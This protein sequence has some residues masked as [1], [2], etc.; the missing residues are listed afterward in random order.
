MDTGERPPKEANEGGSVRA[1]RL[2]G[3]AAPPVF[4]ELGQLPAS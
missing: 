3:E 2:R 4:E 1:G